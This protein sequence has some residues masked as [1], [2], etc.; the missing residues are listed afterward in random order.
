[1]YIDKIETNVHFDLHYDTAFRIVYVFISDSFT[2][3]SFEGTSRET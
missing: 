3:N 1:M 2:Y